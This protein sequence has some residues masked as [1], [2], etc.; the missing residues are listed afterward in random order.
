MIGQ[1]FFKGS[2]ISFDNFDEHVYRSCFLW[3]KIIGPISITD[4]VFRSFEI[5]V[6]E[7]SPSEVCSYK[8]SPSEVCSYKISPS[9]ICLSEISFL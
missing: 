8:I 9:K 7:I 5:R 4:A 6:I 2:L 3:V 1:L